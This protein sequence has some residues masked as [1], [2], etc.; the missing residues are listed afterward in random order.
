MKKKIPTE[1]WFILGKSFTVWKSF[2]PNLR[3]PVK[4]GDHT[5]F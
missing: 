1:T 3:G 4:A 5:M 2:R